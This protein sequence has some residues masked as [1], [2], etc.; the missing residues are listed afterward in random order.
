MEQLEDGGVAYRLKQPRQ[1]GETHRVMT[2]QEFMAR[3]VALIPPPR[4]PLVRYPACSRRTHRGARWWCQVRVDRITATARS[5]LDVVTTASSSRT[6]ITS[7]A[8]SRCARR[9]RVSRL[10]NR[11]R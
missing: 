7:R 9:L 2:G 11:S 6:A 1:G 10:C 8:T 5:A 3:L 4:S